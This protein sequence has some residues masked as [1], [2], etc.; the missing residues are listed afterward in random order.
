MMRL[1]LAG[2]PG[3]NDEQLFRDSVGVQVRRWNP[4][5]PDAPN[6][7]TV[8]LT[9]TRGGYAGS[10]VLRDG[11]GAVVFTQSYPATSRC[12][13]L[14]GDLAFALA[15][16]I[17]PPTPRPPPKPCAAPPASGDARKEHPAY[18]DSRY[19]IWPTEWP[20]PPFQRPKPDPPKPVEKPFA[21]RF[22]A[23]VWVERVAT[24]FGSYGFTVEAGVRYRFVSLGLEV[25][26]DPPLGSV[27]YPDGVGPVSFARVSGALLLCGHFGWFAGCGIADV[28]RFL[29]PEHVSALPASALYAAAGVRVGLEFPIAPPWFL[30]RVAADLR[31]PIHP[32]KY[33]TTSGTIFESAGP[34]AGLGFGLVVELPR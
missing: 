9:R 32:A 24:N 31:A 6:L 20:M 10:A 7:L 11:S 1:V 25:H 30:L 15:L 12:V 5:A 29:F 33:V 26:G 27:T 16:R 22:G 3:C 28:G 23:A 13:D 18:S 17:D 19:A 14:M 21:I 34:G 2:V 4:L 8:T